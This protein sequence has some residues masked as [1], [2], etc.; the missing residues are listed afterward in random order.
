MGT[1]CRLGPQIG[2][3]LRPGGCGVYGAIGGS[4]DLNWGFAWRC[5][6]PGVAG[7]GAFARVPTCQPYGRRF[8]AC[9]LLIISM[10]EAWG[11]VAGAVATATTPG[12]VIGG[13]LRCSQCD[14]MLMGLAVFV[15][16]LAGFFTYRTMIGHWY[17]F[18]NK[19]AVTNLEGICGEGTDWGLGRGGI[20][21]PGG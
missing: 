3:G 21:R 17:G 2:E 4:F 13:S 9:F 18:G 15:G 16:T 11:A 1:D 14:L 19:A 7:D 12:S 20:P 5:A 10:P 8:C 6:A